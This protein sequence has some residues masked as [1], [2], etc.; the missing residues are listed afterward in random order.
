MI[1][2]EEYLKDWESTSLVE[3]DSIALIKRMDTKYVIHIRELPLILSKIKSQYRVL[4]IN[5]ARVFGYQTNYFDTPDFQFYLE[6]HN[7]YTRREKVRFR[8][9]QNSDLKFFEI[10]KKLPSDQT[11]KIRIPV[12]EMQEELNL[13]Q[14]RLVGENKL[15]NRILEKKVTNL[16]KRVTLAQFELRERVT[17]DTDIE[18]SVA[19]KKITLPQ[20]AILELKQPRVNINS[21]LV[22]I[23]K[24]MRIYP[25]SFSKYAMA[26]VMLDLCQKKNEFK[27]QLLKLNKIM[28]FHNVS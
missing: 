6:H 11:D 28:N 21:P 9:Y 1:D 24:K 7:G 16:F 5:G 8:A 23:L 10:K 20:I 3:L 14:Y 27:P 13:D 2:F 19:D 12:G 17:I 25:S 15:R 26:V 4:E 18:F 22:Q